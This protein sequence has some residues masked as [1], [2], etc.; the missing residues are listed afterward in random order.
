MVM[1]S[2][3]GAPAAGARALRTCAARLVVALLAACSEGREPDASAAERANIVW[4]V[5]D[6]QA[7]SSLPHM[8]IVA[9]DLVATGTTFPNFILNDPICCPSRVTMLLGQYRHNHHNEFG[10]S[11]GCSYR[12][13][14]AGDQ[15]RS[16]GRLL[17]AAGYRTGYLGK[18]LNSYEV[19]LKWGGKRAAED[20]ILTGW[21]D[22]AV[23]VGRTDYRDFEIDRNGKLETSP[24][25]VHQN[26]WLAERAVAFLRESGGASEPFFLVVAPQAPHA[27]ARP[28][29]RHLGRFARERAPRVASFNHSDLKTQPSLAG[30]RRLGPGQVRKIDARYRAHL[31]VLQ[32]VDEMV[33]TVV[34]TLS[35]IGQLDRTFIFFTSDHGLHFGEH[36]IPRGKGTPFEESIRFPL[37]VRGPGVPAGAT[38]PE[39]VSN[40][41]LHPTLL[42]LIGESP[43]PE[44]DGRSLLPLLGE[45]REV[46]WRHALL[47]ESTHEPRNTGVP[48]FAGVRADRYKWIRYTDGAAELYDLERDPHELRSIRDEAPM[49]AERAEAQLDALLACHGES[50]REAEA[51]A[52]DSKHPAPRPDVEGR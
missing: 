47:L 11:L 18:F 28:A 30:T 15:H 49:L 45:A 22:Y 50:C 1:T 38:R 12:F 10:G 52:F 36:R 44:V 39:L 32:S 46:P 20:P 17:Q 5:T 14:H 41:D 21:D 37:L 27:P 19:Y 23:L 25:G 34:A 24:P 42:A 48:A 35:E 33:G 26:D 43:A 13:F 2:D 6:D 3:A 9:R 16:I 40:V 29:A 4:I 8:P 51:Y 7:A 31:E